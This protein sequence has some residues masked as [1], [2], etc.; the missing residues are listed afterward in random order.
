MSDAFSQLIPNAQQFFAALH[1]DNTKDWFETHKSQYTDHIRKPAEV[2]G[3]M[4]AV[5]LGRLTGRAMSPK[6]Y[7]INRDVRF[8]KDK[9][10]YN[11]HL[12]LLWSMG[13]DDRPSWF[14]AVSLASVSLS[15][16][17]MGFT[18]GGLDW[19]RHAVADDPQPWMDAVNAI[20]AQGGE[21]ADWGE[22]PLKRVPKPWEES[23]PGSDLLRRKSLILTLPLDG[24]DLSLGLIPVLLIAAE[25]LLPFWECFDAGDTP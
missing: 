12:H 14:F 4:M 20:R 21:I 1:A 22:P 13:G 11:T 5:E 16:G 15:T 17:V 10:P 9:S 25:R 7:R 23:H 24:T 19:A 8:S 2:L 6:V 18:P 3:E